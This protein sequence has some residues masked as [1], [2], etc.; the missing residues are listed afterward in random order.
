MSSA[1]IRR[2]RFVYVIGPSV[3][4]LKIGISRNVAT[5]RYELQRT[6][7]VELAIIASWKLPSFECVDVERHAHWLL[8]SC[9]TRGEWFSCQPA[10]AIAAVERAI[11][12]VRS[13]TAVSERN[14]PPRQWMIKDMPI[15]ARKLA[16]EHA[17]RRGVTMAQWITEAIEMQ[18]RTEW[19]NGFPSPDSHPD[20]HNP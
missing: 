15:A 14:E 12:S 17:R 20:S 7:G 3:G 11:R 13:G 1:A 6:N 9:R 19:P 10:E 4:D 8:R 16:R 18:L 5:R 2:T